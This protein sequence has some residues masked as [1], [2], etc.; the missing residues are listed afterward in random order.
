MDNPLKIGLVGYHCNSGLGELN[1]QLVTYLPISRWLIKPHPS[2]PTKPLT[3]TISTI[4]ANG[5]H[6]AR[7]VQSVDI[8]LFCE[9][10]FHKNVLSSCKMFNKPSVCIPMIEWTPQVEWT[11]DVDLFI[12]PTRQCYRLLKQESLPCVYFPWPVDIQRFQYNPRETCNRFLFL[13]G[14][15][16]WG[17]RKGIKVIQQAKEIWP[18]MPLVVSSQEKTKWPAGVE[19][20]EPQP[21]NSNLYSYGDVLIAPHSVDG[22]G[23]EPMEAMACGMPV[24]STDGEPWNEIPS[25]AKINSTVEQRVI[26]RAVDWHVPDPCSLVDACRSLVGR[27]IL[28]Y[29]RAARYWATGRDWSRQAKVLLGLLQEV[30]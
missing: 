18:E 15:G 28:S 19:F 9:R 22:L 25:I 29:S 27:N 23:L 12:C 20:V 30:L 21:E 3:S 24:V 1:R 13:N 16:G 10:P 2:L 7:F 4:C 17:G 14:H 8:V 6:V 26:N 11:K 5:R